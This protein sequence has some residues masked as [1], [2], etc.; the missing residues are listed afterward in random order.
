MRNAHERAAASADRRAVQF[1]QVKGVEDDVAAWRRAVLG[2][3]RI[4]PEA[5]P[6]NDDP[7]TA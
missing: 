2:A 1:Q 3:Q 4:K 7:A 6:V 5:V